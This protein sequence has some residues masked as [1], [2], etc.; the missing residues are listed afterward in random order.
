MCGT[1]REFVGECRRVLRP[2]GRLMMTTPN[3]LTFSPGLDTPV[4]PVPHEGVHGG[5]ADRAGRR[6]RVR[7][8][9]RARACT[10]AP[11]LRRPGCSLRLVRR[12]ATRRPPPERWPAELLRDVT[13]V[14]TADFPIHERRHRR[15]TR[16][17]RPRPPARLTSS[18]GRG[19]HR[20]ELRQRQRRRRRS[21]GS[22]PAAARA[23]PSRTG[24]RRCPGRTSHPSRCSTRAPGR[25][26]GATK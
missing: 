10:P 6:A 21:A 19:K 7:R 13:S 25:C 17:A 26:T 9:R 5:R 11:R 1:T 4:N 14:T 18:R 3:R 12:R 24:G 20:P 2:G 8:R 15:V 16:P 23:R 22:S